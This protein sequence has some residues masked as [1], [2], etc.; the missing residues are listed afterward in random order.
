M[1]WKQVLAKRKLVPKPIPA[2]TIERAL[3]SA[4]EEGGLKLE[5]TVRD[6]PRGDDKNPGEYFWER[7]AFNLN[8][9]DLTSDEA[10]SFVTTEAERQPVSRLV[11]EKIALRTL[12]DSVRGQLKNWNDG[13]IQSGELT[14]RCIAATDER[15][16]LR[17]E[18]SV[19]L[20]QDGR[21]YVCQLFGRATFDRQE[22]RFQQF[23]LCASGQRSGKGEFNAR[24]NDLG[25]APMGVALVMRELKRKQRSG[26]SET[27]R[28]I[29]TNR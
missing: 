18:G 8:W 23:E 24:D 3:G 12:K 4:I 26:D 27:V 15:L 19:H 9:L 17:F 28:I 6:L 20:R 16:E 7:G 1:K 21:Q 25:P 13:A 14:K 10:K 22:R 29:S 5:V 2:S 11:M